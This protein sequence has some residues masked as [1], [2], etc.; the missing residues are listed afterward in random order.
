MCLI[1]LSWQQ[2]PDFPLVVASN[3]DEFHNRPTESARWWPD[4][5]DILG[6]RDLQAGGTWFALHRDGRFSAVTNYRDADAPSARDRSRGHLVTDFLLGA[7]KPVDYLSMINGSDYAGFNLL[8]SD[9]ESLAYLSNRE[10][11]IRELQPGVYGLAN[12][13][14]DSPW[15]KVLRSKEAMEQLIDSDKINETELLRMLDDRQKAPANTIESSRLP[16]STAHAISAPFIVLPDYGTRCSTVA[17]RDLAGN[18]S[19]RERRFDAAGTNTGESAFRVDP[20]QP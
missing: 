19:M 12:E 2:H 9:G 11:E 17:L 14:L 4:E 15:H 1:V 3:R 13:L 6:G 18:W 10:D 20:A 16:F 5:S 8:V 7:D